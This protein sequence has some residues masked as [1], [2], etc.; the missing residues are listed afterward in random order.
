MIYVIR[1][2][3]DEVFEAL[4]KSLKHSSDAVAFQARD[5]VIMVDL[6]CAIKIDYKNNL[7]RFKGWEV[8]PEDLMLD[9]DGEWI[10]TNCQR[11]RTFEISEDGYIIENRKEK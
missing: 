5:R 7:R 8:L 3:I 10:V 1:P 9:S 4:D 2:S 11:Y 6:E